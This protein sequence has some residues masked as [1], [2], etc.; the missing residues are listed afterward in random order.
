LTKETI[1]LLHM[2]NQRGMHARRS[3]AEDRQQVG[4]AMAGKADTRK[5]THQKAYY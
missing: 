2:L 3:I 1:N 4:P 5:H